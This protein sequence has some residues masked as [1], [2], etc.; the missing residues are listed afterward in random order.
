MEQVRHAQY[1]SSFASK[2]LYLFCGCFVLSRRVP[3]RENE[4]LEV[5]S[6][7]STP[8]TGEPHP[9]PDAQ[10]PEASAVHTLL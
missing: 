3:N 10:S 7:V 2:F 8:Q 6:Q 1:S 9:Q 4:K 5:S